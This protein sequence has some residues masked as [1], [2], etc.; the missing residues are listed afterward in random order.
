M[1]WQGQVEAWALWFPPEAAT[2]HRLAGAWQPGSRLLQA[3]GGM[4]LLL[5]SPRPVRAELSLALPVAALGDG[6]ASYPSARP[7]RDELVLFWQ[8]QSWSARLADLPPV[9]LAELWDGSGLEF[10]VGRPLQEP[11]KRPLPPKPS[12]VESLRDILPSL[13]SPAPE[14]EEWLQR[15]ESRPESPSNPLHR[16]FG[17][18]LGLLGRSHDQRYLDKM[19]RLFEKGDWEQ[20]LRYAIPLKEGTFPGEVI[21]AFRGLFRPRKSL[22]FSPQGGSHY[23]VGTSMSGMEMLRAVYR[24]ACDSL[25]KAGRY[26]EAAY[27][28]GELLDDPVA[29]VEMLEQQQMYEAAARLATT[30]GLPPELLVRLWFRAGK[31]DKA[32]ELARR[33]QVWAEAFVALERLDRPAA[34]RF[35]IAWATDLARL[36]LAAEALE[37]GWSV[38]PR[39]P[40]YQRWVEETLAAGGAPAWKAAALVVSDSG[41]SRDVRLGE[42][43]EGWFSSDGPLTTEGRRIVLGGLPST[44]TED[45]RIA[46]WAE[47]TA[48]GVMKQAGGPFALG[49]DKTLAALIKLSGDPWLKVD[50]P[51]TLPRLNLRLEGWSETVR[52]RGQ[53]PLY[54]AT[55]LGDGRTLLALGHAGL[56]VTSRRG[57]FSQS[58]SLP[59]HRLVLPTRG[60]LYLIVSGNGLGVFQ[61]GRAAAWCSA[62]MAG[63]ADTHDGYH[64]WVWQEAE[65]FRVDLTPDGEGHRGWA[66]LE[67]M[68]FRTAIREVKV[69]ARDVAVLTEDELSL[70]RLPGMTVLSHRPYHDTNPF[71]LSSTGCR[72]LSRKFG[73]VRYEGVDLGLQGEVIGAH[74]FETHAVV[75]AR[76][77]EGVN[78][79]AFPY[80]SLRHKF[81][82]RLPGAAFA[83]ARIHG[84][85]LTVCDS[86]GRLL[87]ADL[88][89]QQ[90]LSQHFL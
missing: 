12:P 36:G 83:R 49:D 9:E 18:L 42:V 74:D 16:A 30:K 8:G 29:A 15:Q 7:A 34:G 50:A 4:L 75:Y 44:A 5:P 84:Y 57:T 6:W 25:M 14:R 51:T 17:T 56:A 48:R 3:G 69:G 39:L 21:R 53:L 13:P 78:L 62:R 58:F 52:S 10:E 82:L 80:S 71:L 77:E 22:D 72:F 11:R 40:E 88:R 47:R 76:D 55:P 38:R 1:R 28:M 68:A 90:W 54:D 24:S 33:H 19:L 23:V 45:L 20:A 46:S 61:R 86:Q 32:L 27:V 2:S 70:Y 81:N 79:C 89:A 66:A 37:V 87:S 65:L 73:Q 31:V 64:W 67:Q 43:L 63:H 59:A 60:D 85:Q 26:E 41:L 35:R